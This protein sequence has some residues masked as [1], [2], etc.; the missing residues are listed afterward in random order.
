MEKGGVQ[1]LLGHSDPPVPCSDSTALTSVYTPHKYACF[2]FLTPAACT[3]E[4]TGPQRP[5]QVSVCSAQ[6]SGEP[7]QALPCL[8]L[9]ATP[10]VSGP[11]GLKHRD[12]DW[13]VCFSYGLSSWE[14]SSPSLGPEIARGSLPWWGSFSHGSPEGGHPTSPRRMG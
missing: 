4:G 8:F 1:P 3:T 6:D 7:R 12:P 9:P 5:P 11:L 2:S 10:R 13:L 14:A